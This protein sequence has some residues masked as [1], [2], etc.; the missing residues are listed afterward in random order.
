MLVFRGS[1]C[2]LRL[3]F[4]FGAGVRVRSHVYV[5]ADSNNN[6]L[7]SDFGILRNSS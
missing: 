1:V 6:E 7:N 2:C 5:S 3:E 4:A